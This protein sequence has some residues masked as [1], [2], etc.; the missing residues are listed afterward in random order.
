M[1]K[2]RSPLWRRIWLTAASAAT[3][4]ASVYALAAPFHSSN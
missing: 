1:R 3:L 2:H 4:A